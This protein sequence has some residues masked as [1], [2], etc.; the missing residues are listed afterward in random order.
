MLAARVVDG[1][2]EAGVLLSAS[3]P[4][5]AALKIRPP[6]PFGQEHANRLLEALD[7]VL[8]KVA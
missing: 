1:M 8:G 3:G 5:A 4:A 6:L 7:E 2:R